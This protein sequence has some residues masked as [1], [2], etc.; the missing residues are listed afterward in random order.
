MRSVS[1]AI[2]FCV[3]VF[4]PSMAGAAPQGL[5]GKSVTVTWTETRSQRGAGETAFRPVS[6]PFTY[7]VYVSSEGRPFK[8]LTSVSSTR[9][10]TGSVD[11]VGLGAP[12]TGGG[13]GTLQFVGN[14]IVANS[15]S[16]GGFGRRIEINA[17]GGFGSCSAR[18]ISGMTPGKKVASVK[19]V[20]T[21]NKVEF[22]SI[23][24]GPASC[25]IRAGNA[26][27]S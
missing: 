5:F 19:S 8:R 16:P 17:D 13:A 18:I 9:R 10:A 7:T 21:G 6:L 27:A 23:S 4:W 2:L 15:S 12:G 22:E 20:A 26:F 24:A 11:Q 3:A 1:S 14:T 25:S